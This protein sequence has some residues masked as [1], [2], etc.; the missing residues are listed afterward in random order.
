MTTQRRTGKKS[1]L[2]GMSAVK[3]PMHPASAALATG[4][5]ADVMKDVAQSPARERATTRKR[6]GEGPRT[7]AANARLSVNFW[8]EQDYAD[9]R[10]A[11]Q[12]EYDHPSDPTITN[13]KTWFAQAVTVYAAL[14][15]AERAAIREAMA[16]ERMD[17]PT[18]KIVRSIDTDENIKAT[19][20]KGVFEDYTR[21]ARINASAYAAEAIYAAVKRT[22][23]QHPRPW[24]VPTGRLLAKPKDVW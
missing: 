9:M 18:T 24:V 1:V 22:E 15:P 5:P 13:L 14:D 19:I 10:S 4:Q 23:Q 2:S 11:Y 21:G 20:V 7:A 8:S 17:R 16:A 6:G 3:P 12:L